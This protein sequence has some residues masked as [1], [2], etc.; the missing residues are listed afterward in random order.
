MRNT[1][2]LFGNGI[3]QLLAQEM[4]EDLQ[5][6]REEAIAAAKKQPGRRVERSLTTKGV[7]FGTIA[8]TTS[9]DGAVTLDASGRRGVDPDLV[10]RPMGW[11]GHITTVRTITAGAAAAVMGMLPEELVWKLQEQ[12]A[13]GD[14]PDGDGVERELSVGDVTAM[15]VYGSAQE[16]PQ[17]L[18]RLVEL[19]LA[20]PPS[21]ADRKRVEEGRL[22]FEKVGCATCHVPSLRL[23][24]TVF[25]EPTLRGNGHYYDT[26]LASKDEGYD[27]AR[28][29]RFDILRD[30][31]EPRPDS[32]R[33]GGA[34]I[35]A[36]GDLK[37]HRMGRPLADPGGPQPS[38][39][40]SGAP[41]TY[42]GQPVLIPADEYLTPELWG[43]GNTGPW[44]HDGR[45]AGL[46]EAIMWHGEDTPPPVGDPGR[47]EAQES[48]DAFAALSDGDQQAVLM[49][50]R[51]LR[52]YSQPPRQR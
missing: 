21:A 30:A 11:K 51:S 27:T 32:H 19:G 43:V 24:N 13:K 33:D 18:E 36:Y 6:L 46:R 35:L 3:L 38:S 2:S 50:L 9:Q 44:L 40:G 28:P 48:R 49:F 39:D 47:S 34:T 42:D 41:V 4:T 16:T 1:T 23:E 15:V 31:Q 20:A 10:V 26:F 7:D 14:D 37:R 8:A 52:T 45:A 17:P 22:L 5:A 12:G 25:E 29:V